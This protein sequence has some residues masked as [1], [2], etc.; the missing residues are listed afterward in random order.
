MI[1]DLVKE[2][3]VFLV[4][5]IVWNLKDGHYQRIISKLDDNFVLSKGW[6]S[7]M[8]D[9]EMMERSSTVS[10]KDKLVPT[11]KMPDN[12][13]IAPCHPPDFKEW[14]PIKDKHNSK[15]IIG[16]K[17]INGKDKPIYAPYY[18]RNGVYAGWQK[19]YESA[20]RA[21]PKELI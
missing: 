1:G 3:G 7:R 9:W 6:S 17:R 13:V 16:W 5:H 4:G 18:A 12:Y 8:A 19:K 11:A 10:D 2:K 15:R 14:E 20:M 21:Y